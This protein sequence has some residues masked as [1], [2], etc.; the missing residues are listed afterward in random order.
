MKGFK[1]NING[2]LRDLDTMIVK[3]ISDDSLIHKIKSIGQ[4]MRFFFKFS[5]THKFYSDVSLLVPRTCI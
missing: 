5:K 1:N 2:L 3:K 4:N